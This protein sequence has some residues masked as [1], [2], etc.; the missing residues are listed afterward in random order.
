MRE[1]RASDLTLL[2][3]LALSGC[4]AQARAPAHHPAA[5]SDGADPA[6]SCGVPA[7]VGI[8]L[9]AELAQGRAAES[10]AI[11]KC[12]A[13][14]ARNGSVPAEMLLA[15]AY[16]RA[17]G[18]GRP[19]ASGSAALGIDLF[20]RHIGW[21]HMAA[22]RG[23]PAAQFLLAQETDGP[24][25]IAMPDSTLAW[26]QTAAENGSGPARAAIATAYRQGRISEE[27]LYDFRNWLAAHP[28]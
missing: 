19:T 15:D 2:L 24:L 1:R 7:M 25:A 5:V 3:G 16:R 22:D 14:N 6:G 9:A 20:G 11:G 10:S 4:H 28:R 23:Y 21:L 27:R 12:N 8:A 17:M 26:Y 13:A 18:A